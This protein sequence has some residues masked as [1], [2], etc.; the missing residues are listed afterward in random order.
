LT[1]NIKN[2][3]LNGVYKKANS[4]VALSGIT[5][6]SIQFDRVRDLRSKLTNGSSKEAKLVAKACDD[7]LNPERRE[8]PKFELKPFILEEM[9]RLNNDELFRYLYYRYRYDIYPSTQQLDAFP[10]CVQIEPT[11]ICNYRCVFCYQTD[12]KLTQGRHGHMGM[13]DLDVFKLIIDQIENRVEAV[14]LASRGEPLM[15]KDIISMLEYLSDKFLGLKLNTNA[16]FL[17]EKKAHAILAAEPNTLVFSADAADKELYAKLRV[18]GDLDTVLSN[19]QIFND[20]K[21]K[22]YSNSRTIT[23]VSGVRYND[24]QDFS[25]IEAF[26]HD[27]VDQV[28]FVAY[29]PWESAYEAPENDI[30]DHCSDLWRRTFIWWDGTVNPCDVDYR[31]TLATGNIKEENLTEIWQGKKYQKLRHL[32]SNGARCSLKPCSGCALV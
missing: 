7:L 3:S 1:K 10:P 18:N 6:N 8:S 15:A 16:S 21:S 31:S 30:V 25:E 2:S 28:A 20:I 11:S 29:N 23:R 26:W 17:T 13:M 5:E 32:H 12:P 9:Q 14:T 19:I 4:F 24:K 22:H 27:Y